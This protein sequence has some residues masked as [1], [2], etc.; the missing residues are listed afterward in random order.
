MKSEINFLLNGEAVTLDFSQ[1]RDLY[2][3]MTVMKYLREF[4]RL[5]GTKEGCGIGDC[6]ACTVAIAGKVGGDKVILISANSC[7]MMLGM[8]DNKHLITVEGVSGGKELHPVQVSLLKRRGA[9]CGFC[10]PG[11]VVS[12]FV[13]YENRK[14]FTTDSVREALSGNLCR[15]TGYESIREALLDIKNLRTESSV[16]LIDLPLTSTDD[17]V[18][19][20]K[21]GAYIKPVDLKS[22]LKYFKECPEYDIVCGA[23]DTSV[24]NKI[25]EPEHCYLI[26]IS[27]ISDLKRVENSGDYI[28]IGSAT[29]IESVREG[30][31]K[32]YPRVN[33]YL[34]SFA[35]LPIRN[36]ASIGGNVAGASA[37]GDIMPMLLAMNAKMRLLSYSDERIIDCKDF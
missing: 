14:D 24:K 30:L 31:C 12:S 3:H 5:T 32:F 20:G 10:T 37:V 35:S 36:S 6:G 21:R 15:C 11:V 22:L 25:E 34:L 4:R 19:K 28:I 9:Q 13:H 8:L 23:S 2:P 16:N 33:D 18:W 29:S 27:D 1:E 7:L 26:D 17:F